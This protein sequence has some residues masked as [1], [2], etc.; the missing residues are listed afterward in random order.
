MKTVE[1]SNSSDL[2]QEVRHRH[3]DQR[4]KCQGMLQFVGQQRLQS[5]TQISV[6][7]NV[8]TLAEDVL[9]G[10]IATQLR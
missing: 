9:S 1:Q 10:N 3:I 7:N 2:S 6:K 4:V 8:P 5:H